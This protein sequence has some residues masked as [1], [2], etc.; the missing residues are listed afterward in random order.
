M[1]TSEAPVDTAAHPLD[2]LTEQEIS[3]AR[4]ILVAAGIVTDDTR[5][6]YLGRAEPDK[7]AVR[8]HQAGVAAQRVIRAF[9]IDA[10][11]GELRDVRVSLDTGE[12]VSDRVIDPVREGQLPILDQD[13][14]RAEEI[15][16][17]DPE[18]LAAMARRGLTDPS[19]IRA[20]PLSAGNY[21]YED[22]LGRRMVRVLSFYQPDDQSPPWAHP[23]DGVAA[24]V[25]LVA[26]RVFRL[27]DDELMPV[28]EESGR[29]DEVAHRTTLK[30]IEITQPEGSSL[31]LS[32]NQVSW[33]NWQLRV[34]FDAREGLTLHQISYDDRSIIYRAAISE[35]VIPY[36]DPSPVRFWQNYFDSGEY[37]L[38]KFANSLELGCDCLGEISYLDAVVADDFG[39]PRTIK[40]AICIHEEDFGILW[41]HHEIFTGRSDTRR[42]RRLV[43]SF[44]STVGNYDY[45]FYWYFY[46]DGTIEME[47]K[48]TGVVFTS[49]YP[50]DGYPYATQVAPG[51]GAPSHQ[52]LFN[53]RLDMAVAGDRNTVDE[54]DI[55]RLPMGKDNP[56]GNV[57][58]RRITRLTNERDAM[59]D[60]AADR[61][62]VWRIGNP[63][64]VNRFGEPVAYVLFPQQQP[65]LIADSASA[66]H[67]RA[68]FATRSLWVTRYAPNELYAAGDFVNQSPPGKGLPEYV[69]RD[70]GV[71]GEDIVVWHTFGLTH[72]PRLEDWPVMPVDRC[73]FT[74]KPYGFFDRN[75]TLDVPP[76]TADHCH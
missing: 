55:E 33:Q 70:A 43:I 37:L 12:V 14:V 30:P 10:V 2:L 20:C 8:E 63:D 60:A 36:G 3:A 23:I 47:V 44:F 62:R 45:G 72:F 56:Y 5:F 26:G 42:Q 46:L 71:D 25:D 76:T 74:L 19:K 13:F 38:G 48:A 6:G 49:A 17:A 9:L 67:G 35:M 24:Y 41:K 61:G 66:L 15:V 18:W 51:L 65:T 52:H 31:E 1:Q 58:G 34:G 64:V 69:Q 28:P 29:L 73:G 22:E 40:N 11:S 59:R 4:A 32:G 39:N 7:T 50:G 21:G 16:H 57:I 27:I 54:I 75:P 53:A 68:G